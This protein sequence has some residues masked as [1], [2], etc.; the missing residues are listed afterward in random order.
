MCF[1][2]P[3]VLSFAFEIFALQ[4]VKGLKFVH[5]ILNLFEYIGD[6]C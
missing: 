2:R 6:F 3:L 1:D 5:M 4:I